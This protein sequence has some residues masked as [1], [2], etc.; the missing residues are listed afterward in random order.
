MEQL[1]V[2]DEPVSIGEWQLSLEALRAKR[3]RERTG[4]AVVVA[5]RTVYPVAP[6]SA[7]FG[8]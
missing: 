6:A 7:P 3:V 2:A 1:R 8:P 5:G 4:E